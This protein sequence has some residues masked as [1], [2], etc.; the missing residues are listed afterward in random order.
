MDIDSADIN[1]TDIKLTSN[2]G[3]RKPPVRCYYCNNLGHIRANCHKY[4]A[5]QEDE[6]NTETE[7][8]TTNQRN[9]GGGRTQRVLPTHHS[10]LLMAHI[11]S[12]RMEDR[13]DFLDHILSQ[14]ENLPECPGTA[15]YARTTEAS[16]AYAGRTKVMRI[17]IALSLVS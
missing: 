16:T 3:E 9:T 4:K 1:P 12:M 14:S 6:P 7:V 13:D 17:K 5:A 11:R 10:E 2:E 15:I 8:Q